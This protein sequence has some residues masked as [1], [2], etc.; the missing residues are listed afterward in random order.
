[1]VSPLVV[2]AAGVALVAIVAYFVLSG[3]SRVKLSKVEY[4]M[5]PLI[6]KVSSSPATKCSVQISLYTAS[7]VLYRIRAS[8]LLSK[9]SY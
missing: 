9:F 5:F 2:V 8:C 6:E 7:E 3:P 4:K 1:M